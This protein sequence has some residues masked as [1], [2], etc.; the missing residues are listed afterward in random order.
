MNGWSSMA[1]MDLGNGI[2][3]L[4]RVEQGDEGAWT[5]ADAG[6][7]WTCSGLPMSRLF[8]LTRKK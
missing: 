3:V 7:C 1:T 8:L 2:H 6:S 4:R 5:P